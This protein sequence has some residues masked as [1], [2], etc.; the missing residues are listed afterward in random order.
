MSQL[1]P[2]PSANT[3]N[4][5]LPPRRDP[6]E[7]PSPQQPTR[8]ATIKPHRGHAQS[9][10]R[11]AY[12]RPRPTPRYSL[13]THNDRLVNELA[14]CMTDFKLDSLAPNL[15]PML[16][17]AVESPLL[18]A[19]LTLI[20]TYYRQIL[21]Q[22]QGGVPN[23]APVV[24]SYG[25]AIALARRYV[26]SPTM[27]DTDETLVGCN[28]LGM[29]DCMIAMCS[30]GWTY[31]VKHWKGVATLLRRRSSSVMAVR[32]EA[33]RSA[34]CSGGLYTL[35]IPLFQGVPSW[36]EA[37]HWLKAEPVGPVGAVEV[38]RLR[39]YSHQ[40]CIRLP[41]L[42]C[43]VRAVR[44]DASD[45]DTVSEAV[46]LSTELLELEDLDGESW[47]LHQ[48]KI[49]ATKDS[50]D[51]II[52]PISLQYDELDH[53]TWALTYWQTRLMVIRLHIILDSLH[54][55]KFFDRERG[56]PLPSL[57]ETK[58]ASLR[59]DELRLAR[60]VLMTW[61]QMREA[62]PYSTACMSLALLATWT[63]FRHHKE[64]RP[65]V[66]ASNLALWVVK[67]MKH[68]WAGWLIPPR[69]EVFESI[70]DV[71]EGGPL[72]AHMVTLLGGEV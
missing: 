5:R 43:A 20:A 55:Y 50:K 64:L 24:R 72:D 40:L 44:E 35:I 71:L 69:L 63:C 3:S 18:S 56:L 41:R 2:L 11:I 39:Q 28:L 14:Q 4:V 29:A 6:A 1:S 42:V 31:S 34:L 57:T 13:L 21:P 27:Y 67:N 48:T 16:P 22:H 25:K 46:M 10:G 17:V 7:A 66:P 23:L 61:Q 70:C 49:V 9:Q 65:G 12:L 60:N 37:Q 68:S 32:N 62:G 19:I 26:A 51:I 52:T 15:R 36:F 38:R 30:P 8:Y 58:L 33:V 59:K 53:M 54:E 45:L 47:L